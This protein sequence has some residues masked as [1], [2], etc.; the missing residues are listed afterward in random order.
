MG[1]NRYGLR[2]GLDTKVLNIG[3]H[4]NRVQDTKAYFGRSVVPHA[5]TQEVL[6]VRLEKLDVTYHWSQ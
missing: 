5:C 3:V 6:R 4:S 2:K 1:S